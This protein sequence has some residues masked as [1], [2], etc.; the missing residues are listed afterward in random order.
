MRITFRALFLS[1][2]SLFILGGCSN[3]PAAPPPVNMDNFQEVQK[4]QEEVHR[5]EYGGEATKKR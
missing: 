1:G 3:E 5:K 4:K 2:F